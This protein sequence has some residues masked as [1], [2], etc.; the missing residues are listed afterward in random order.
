LHAENLDVRIGFKR[1]TGEHRSTAPGVRET[2]QTYL[3][4]S[5]RNRTQEYISAIGHKQVLK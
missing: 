1:P 3:R 5:A 2:E 4:C